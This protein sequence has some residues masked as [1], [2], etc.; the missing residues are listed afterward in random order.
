MATQPQRRARIV[1]GPFEIDPQAGELFKSGVRIRLPGQSFQILLC[2]VARPGDV[3]TR[4]QLR[5]R[6]WSDGTFVDFEHSLNVAINRLRRALSDSAESPRY[7]ETVPGRGYRFIG[8][9]QE[10]SG[11]QSA[12]S[13]ASPIPALIQTPGPSA[14]RWK[15]RLLRKTWLIATA[16]AALAFFVAGYFYFHRTPKL[17]D[18]DTVVL[19]DF[20][21]TT[22]DPMF[23]ETLRQGLAVQLQ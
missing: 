3:V 16:T 17:T 13:E 9:L 22:R 10:E 11:A 4:E 2:L 1:F 7:I 15:F 12:P 23:D 5:N 19:A 21:N 14:E 6:I 8:S 20:R 18:K